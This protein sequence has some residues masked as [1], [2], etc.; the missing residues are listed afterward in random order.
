MFHNQ[1]SESYY[2]FGSPQTPFLSPKEPQIKVSVLVVIVL[3]YPLLLG[4]MIQKSVKED[5]LE[6]SV[7]KRKNIRKMRK[8]S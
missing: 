4:R 7:R 6:K 1:E 5:N 3:V 2:M 8:H